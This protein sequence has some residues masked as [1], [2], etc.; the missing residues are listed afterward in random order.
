M[1]DMNG[2]VSV[3]KWH[4]ALLSGALFIILSGVSTWLI[5]YQSSLSK[6]LRDTR[7]RVVRLETK[8]GIT[9]TDG[10]S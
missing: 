5:V 6:D 10:G 3:P 9:K 8:H 4:I 7:E 2:T 1:P